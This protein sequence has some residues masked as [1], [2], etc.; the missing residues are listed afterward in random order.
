[1][2][3]GASATLAEDGGAARIAGSDVRLEGADLHTVVAGRVARFRSAGIGAGDRVMVHGDNSVAYV[4]TLLALM[5]LDASIVLVD[6][7]QTRTET[8][9]ALTRVNARWLLHDGATAPV[10][11]GSGR[12]LRY[13]VDG[14]APPVAEKISLVAWGARSDA[15]ILWS[16]GT[17]GP[18]KGVV[19]SGHSVFVNCRQTIRAMGYRP[20]DVLAPWLPFSHQ[21]GLSLVLIWWLTGCGLTLSDYR[22]IDRALADVRR[23]GVTMVDATPSTYHTLVNLIRRRPEAVAELGSVR[24]WGVGGAP[25]SGMLGDAFL[26]TVGSPLLDG[27]G[28]T[29]VGNVAL[30]TPEH[31]R[32]C[33]RPLPG[34]EVRIRAD[35]GRLAAPGSLG[36]V[37]VRSPGLMTGYLSDDGRVTP[38]PDD[39]YQTHDLGMLDAEGNLQVIGRKHA[40]HRHGYTL[41]P[42]S[43]EK[44][45]ER[46]GQPVKVLAIENERSGARLAF[47]VAD[48]EGRPTRHWREQLCAVLAAYEHPN[49]V[50]VVPEYPVNGNGKIDMAAL[51][52]IVQPDD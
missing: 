10:D 19:K 47:V 9:D 21:Y 8:E 22:R 49:S 52:T 17:T 39:W 6:H 51:R 46:C 41:Y 31:P 34:V 27:Y 45:A 13:D 5:H 26:A 30:A 11:L 16:S 23:C 18:A 24:A 20:D 44:R 35:S 14:P 25:L 3:L 38:P 7:R 43:I 28:L 37:E 12:T 1:M 40:V 15:V 42:A 36:E 33:G 50:L 2:K 29:E 32:A 48:P 4:V